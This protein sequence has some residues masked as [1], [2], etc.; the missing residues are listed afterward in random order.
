[1]NELEITNRERTTENKGVKS[2]KVFRLFL[3][4][5]LVRRCRRNSKY[6]ARAFA[7]TLG[8]EN[9]A[10]SKILSGK[11]GL[12]PTMVDR[13]GKNLGLNPSEIAQFII[14]TFVGAG[15]MDQSET[16][17]SF[18]QLTLDQFTVISDWYHYAILELTR[19]PH[20]RE[21]NRWISK[22]LGISIS[23]AGVAL[24]RLQRLGYLEKGKSGR[25]EIAQGSFTTLGN[26]F[27]ASAFR[28]L[29]KQIL[30]KALVA[31]EEVPIEERDQTSMTMATSKRK[32]S[33]AKEMI[34]KFRRQLA[35]FLE[36][37][38]EDLDTVYHLAISLYPATK[39]ER[40]R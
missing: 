29:Q 39:G 12:T 35:Q 27:S 28:K 16:E 17:A 37:D 26:S 32:M 8:I 23:E 2:G 20:F 7:R 6:S 18:Q 4:E 31:L 15:A 34:K 3:Q 22:M 9:S 5:E 10:L 30:E 40:K 21:S 19:L 36:N 38:A 1:M 14:G 24:E 11:R 13:L 33:G 25:L